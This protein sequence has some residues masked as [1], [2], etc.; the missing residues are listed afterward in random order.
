MINNIQDL[1]NYL[2]ISTQGSTTEIARWVDRAFYKAT[3]CGG[4]IT[5]KDNGIVIGSI[6]EGSDAEFSVFLKFPISFDEFENTVE[7]LEASCREEWH[8]ANE[9]DNTY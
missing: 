9:D 7:W 5:L 2:G 6:V 8:A 3:D 4:W 1:A